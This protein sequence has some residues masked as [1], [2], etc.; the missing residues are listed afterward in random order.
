[1]LSLPTNSRTALVAGLADSAPIGYNSIGGWA[2]W[3]LAWPSQDGRA[4]GKSG[5]RRRRL[6]RAGDEI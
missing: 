3:S 6:A 4:G 1:M 2:G 5:H